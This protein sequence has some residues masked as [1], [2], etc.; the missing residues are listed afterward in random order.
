MRRPW[1]ILSLG[2]LGAADPFADFWGPAG[3]PDWSAGFVSP[4]AGATSCGEG[5]F[6]RPSPA[7]VVAMSPGV[8]VGTA[9][10]QVAHRWLENADP[11]VETFTYAGVQS[12]VAKGARVPVGAVLGEASRLQ[13]EGPVGPLRTFL[14]GHASLV[15]PRA[16]AHLGLISHAALELRVYAR[17]QLQ[18]VF[19]VRLGQSTGAKERRGDNR[20]PRGLYFVTERS[21]GPFEGPYADFFGGLWL[22]INYPNPVDAA[23]GLQ[24]GLISKEEAAAIGKA[25]GQRKATPK[26]TR[27]GGGIGIHAWIAP[28]SV[29]DRAGLSWGCVVVQPAD[30]DA[31]DAALPVGSAVVLL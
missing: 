14:A 20:S 8:V 29:A 15:D 22:R 27:L 24:E 9:P 25:W 18:R 13:V 23:R 12:T 6:S 26:N 7:P 1:L 28:W 11:R 2:C 10:L 4:L 17:G 21:R 30:A 31:V 3:A 5:C 19:P 16:E